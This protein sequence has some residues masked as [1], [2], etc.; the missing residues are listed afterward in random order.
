MA[1]LSDFTLTT[2]TA[3]ERLGIKAKTFTRWAN[4]D[5]ELPSILTPGGWR[6]YRPEDIDAFEQRLLNRERAS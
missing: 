5:P 6:R 4:S 3:A 2:A 1:R